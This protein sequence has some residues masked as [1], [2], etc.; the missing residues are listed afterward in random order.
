MPREGTR[1]YE[2]NIA[3]RILNSAQNS[4]ENNN[5]SVK[6]EMYFFNGL[7]TYTTGRDRGRVKTENPEPGIRLKFRSAPEGTKKRVFAVY[8]SKQHHEGLNLSEFDHDWIHK[9]YKEVRRSVLNKIQVVISGHSHGG[10]LTTIF[11]QMLDQDP[12]IPTSKLQNLYVVTFNSIQIIPKSKLKRIK[13]FYQFANTSNIAQAKRRIRMYNVFNKSR[14]IN[15]NN[16]MF[17]SDTWNKSQYENINYR[18]GVNRPNNNSNDFKFNHLHMKFNRNVSKVYYDR[19]YNMLWLWKGVPTRKDE[20]KSYLKNIETNGATIGKYGS[21]IGLTKMFP[22]NV[23]SHIDYDRDKF[24]NSVIAM[25]R[26]TI[27]NSALNV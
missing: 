3:K 18:V 27:Q 11:A 2:N 8:I 4:N 21:F 10:L 25:F 1:G 15:N 16:N 20:I 17:S 13:N 26:E 23:A 14:N 22:R 12:T 19:R 5:S 9:Q 7:S 24:V 6:C